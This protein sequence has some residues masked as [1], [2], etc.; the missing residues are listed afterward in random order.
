MRVCSG[1]IALIAV[2]QFLLIFAPYIVLAGEYPIANIPPSVFEELLFSSIGQVNLDYKFMCP[3]PNSNRVKTLIK[4]DKNGTGLHE[5]WICRSGVKYVEVHYINKVL[6]G[7]YRTIAKYSNGTRVDGYIKN[8]V[9][10][11]RWTF[12]TVRGDFEEKRYTLTIPPSGTV[13][14]G[15]P[16][17]ES[18]N[19]WACGSPPGIT[20]SGRLVNGVKEGL[21]SWVSC[22]PSV[23]NNGGINGIRKVSEGRFVHGKPDGEWRWYNNGVL[24]AII[25]YKKGVANGRFRHN[26]NTYF[27]VI[28][29]EKGG[30]APFDWICNPAGQS[31]QGPGAMVGPLSFY[32]GDGLPIAQYSI[33]EGS[34]RIG[35]PTDGSYGSFTYSGNAAPSYSLATEGKLIN[36]IPEG[37]W[38]M[39]DFAGR[40]CVIATYSKGKVINLSSNCQSQQLVWH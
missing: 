28:G 40:T 34:Q 17:S 32:G 3:P 10:V 31:F 24:Q 25:T 12:T 39:F 36:G 35:I 16:F 38:R 18:F 2:V 4:I 29:Y 11:G 27:I 37:P 19:T 22:N 8:G 9:P 26:C 13:F 5:E 33:K 6:N 21:W 1:N 15:V 23:P 20:E 7:P 14:W 30:R